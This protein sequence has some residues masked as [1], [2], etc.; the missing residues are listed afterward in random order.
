M[1]H[2]LLTSSL[3]SAHLPA[4]LGNAGLAIGMLLLG[5]ILGGV[6]AFIVLKLVAS[7]ALGVAK[8]EAEDLLSK[9]KAE[10][11][12]LAKQIELDARNEQAKRREEFDKETDSTRN[13]LLEKERRLTKREDNLDKKL[14]TL[15]TK[16][17]YL[18]EMDADV[19]KALRR[20]KSSAIMIRGAIHGHRVVSDADRGS[21]LAASAEKS[22]KDG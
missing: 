7:N 13:E 21:L 18:T 10:G 1:I 9:A 8:R 4:T 11:D 19:K 6:A 22:A 3:A 2:S 12:T 14:D 15:T 5:L 20:D 17:K 16:E